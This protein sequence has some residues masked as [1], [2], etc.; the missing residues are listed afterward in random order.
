VLEENF[1]RLKGSQRGVAVRPWG[2]QC[3]GPPSPE[4]VINQVGGEGSRGGATWV[5]TDRA[6]REK[7]KRR[8]AGKGVKD[9]GAQSFH[10]GKEV[11]RIR[12]VPLLPI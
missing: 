8:P 12:L 6:P 4:W 5:K 10:E 9:R 2:K 11:R 7:L 3:R 1:K